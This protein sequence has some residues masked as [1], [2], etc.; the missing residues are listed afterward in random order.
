MTDTLTPRDPWPVIAEIL[1]ATPPG[2][3]F[4]ART[5]HEAAALA[6]LSSRQIGDAQRTA[7]EAG[8]IEPLGQWWG[9]KFLPCVDFTDH[10]E[11]KGRTVF[12]YTRTDKRFPD[13]EPETI[14][15]QLALIEVP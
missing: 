2:A 4:S 15:G 13:Q 1:R 10:A 9:G 5:W 7:K 3:L 11:A 14:D 8:Y 6:Q 12:A